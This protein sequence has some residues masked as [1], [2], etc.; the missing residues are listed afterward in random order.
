MCFG[1][2]HPYS[3]QDILNETEDA[4]YCK[5]KYCDEG[6]ISLSQVQKYD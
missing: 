2:T 5:K 4:Q 6:R 3:A 1:K